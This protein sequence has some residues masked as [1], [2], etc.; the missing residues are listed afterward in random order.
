MCFTPAP[1][2]SFISMAMLTSSGREGCICFSQMRI[3][4]SEVA[5]LSS[6]FLS[7]KLGFKISASRPTTLAFEG[8]FY[9]G[10]NCLTH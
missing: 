6:K 2:V 8:F 3:S 7:Q 9:L 1:F 4:S 5:T 10:I